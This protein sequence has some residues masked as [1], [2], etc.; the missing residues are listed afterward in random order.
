M[1]RLEELSL[2]GAS[3]LAYLG[4]DAVQIKTAFLMIWKIAG[5][6]AEGEEEA[7][8]LSIPSFW[9]L[10]G[11][12]IIESPAASGFPKRLGWAPMTQ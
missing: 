12:G 1:T 8:I 5:L 9:S 2:S 10:A 7:A 3:S 6:S 4:L 11:V